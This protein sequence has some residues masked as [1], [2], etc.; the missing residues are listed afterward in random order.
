MSILLLAGSMPAAMAH[1][2]TSDEGWSGKV[3]S[4]YRNIRY[5]D[6]NSRVDDYLPG[7]QNDESA[8]STAPEDSVVF[9]KVS[10]L[11]GSGYFTDSFSVATG[12]T[13]QVTLTDFEFPNPLAETGLNITSTTESFGS[14]FGTGSFTFDADPGDYYL[15]FFGRAPELG[16]Y[17]IEIAQFAIEISQP[18]NVSTVPVPAAAWLFGSGLLGLTGLVRRRS[19]RTPLLRSNIRHI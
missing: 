8:D 9:E 12:G 15:S 19:A 2:M 5:C 11:S 3:N 6:H 17:G 14:L 4:A 7:G 16:Q 13:Y 10:F 18:G 1:R